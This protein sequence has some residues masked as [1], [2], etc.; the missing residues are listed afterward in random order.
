MFT[1]S[2]STWTQQGPKLVGSETVGG[3]FG[4]GVALSGNG[5]TALVGGWLDNEHAGAAWVFTRSGST[6]RQQGPKLTDGSIVTK[7]GMGFGFSVALSASGDTALV[8]GPGDFGYAD[9]DGQAWVFTRRGSTWRQPGVNLVGNGE[10]S[11]GDAVGASVALSATGNLALVGAPGNTPSGAA[12]TFT[13]SGST[14]RQQGPKLSGSGK[15]S[16]GEQFGNTVALSASGRTAL[17][18]DPLSATPTGV[19]WVYSRS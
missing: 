14:W 17:I 11:G 1:R 5:N 2:G 18:A 10:T 7:R 12:W 6:W 8:G 19:V 15:A 16:E 13:R 9:P 3:N 4:S